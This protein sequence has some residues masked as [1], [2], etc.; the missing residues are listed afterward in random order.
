[1]AKKQ[2]KYYIRPDGLHEA[3]RTINGKRVAFR[4]KTDAEVEQ[5]MIDYKEKE[6]RGP[7]FKEV[8]EKW[9]EEH[10]ELAPSTAKVIQP[11]FIRY[12]TIWMLLKS[13]S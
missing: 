9:K 5:K 1:M 11:S 8:A 13:Y 6:I 10:S 7:L 3:I 2:P 12:K 4:G